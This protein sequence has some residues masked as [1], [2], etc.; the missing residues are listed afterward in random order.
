[1]RP[2]SNEVPM[3]KRIVPP[4]YVRHHIGAYAVDRHPAW[5]FHLAFSPAA[6][7]TQDLDIRVGRWQLDTAWAPPSSSLA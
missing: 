6:P 4:P 3:S 1:L 7:T 2:L 5:R